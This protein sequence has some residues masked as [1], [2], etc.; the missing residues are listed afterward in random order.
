MLDRR[1]AFHGGLFDVFGGDV[2]GKIQPSA[3]FALNRPKGLNRI[4]QALGLGQRGFAGVQPQIAQRRLRGLMPRGKAAMGGEDAIGRPGG[5]EAGN[6]A[7][8]GH[9]GGNLIAPA[10]A[11][12]HVASEVQ[13]GV[14]TA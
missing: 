1:I 13:R 14:P 7:L 9:E 12:V 8:G 4:G 3:A 10:R 5:R 6:R 2:I 11:A